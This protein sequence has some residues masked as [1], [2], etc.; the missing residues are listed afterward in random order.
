MKEQARQIDE[1]REMNMFIKGNP[2]QVYSELKKL[3]R[4]YGKYEQMAVVIADNKLSVHPIMA[5]ALRGLF[6]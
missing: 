1:E 6:K 3:E 2:N 4:I 5:Q